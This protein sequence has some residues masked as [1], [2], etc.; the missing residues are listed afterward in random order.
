MQSDCKENHTTYAPAMCDQLT[1]AQMCLQQR[2][3]CQLKFQKVHCRNVCTWDDREPL[4]HAISLDPFQDFGPCMLLDYCS[5]VM[6]SETYRQV[7]LT[8][9]ITGGCCVVVS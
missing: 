4:K 9:I 6:L 5:Q 2:L 3:S 1:E 8:C 7:I